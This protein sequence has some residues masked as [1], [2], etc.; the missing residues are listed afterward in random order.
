M[1][2]F[3]A[4][5]V[6]E[7]G[8][9]HPISRFVKGWPTVEDAKVSMAIGLR[10]FHLRQVEDGGLSGMVAGLEG[11]LS[12]LHASLP[13]SDHDLLLP[14]KHLFFALRDLEGTGQ[15]ARCFRVKRRGPR[16]SSQIAELRA[17]ALAISDLIMAHKACSRDQADIEAAR[18][19]SRRAKTLGVAT[20]KEDLENWRRNTR[21]R[22]RQG[23][24]HDDRSTTY[25]NTI[26]HLPAGIA[27]IHYRPGPVSLDQRVAA[28]HREINERV[29]PMFGTRE[30]LD[31][32]G[33]LGFLA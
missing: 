18:K 30:Q 19:I 28:I 10:A 14:L 26:H 12:Y 3:C 32:D 24:S 23:G 15:K 33:L 9:Q 16:H 2:E 17:R 5:V 29:A 25:R 20:R 1:V 6:A 11:A 13:P 27:A 4:A 7:L 22:R 8:E 21:G 31:L